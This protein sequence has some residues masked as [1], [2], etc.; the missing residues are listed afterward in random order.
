MLLRKLEM[1]TGLSD[2][3]VEFSLTA[4]RQCRCVHVSSN[5]TIFGSEIQ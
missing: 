1:G 4:L 5:S 3:L 2:G